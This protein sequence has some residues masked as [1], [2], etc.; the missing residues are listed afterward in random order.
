VA[1]LAE[2]YRAHGEDIPWSE[3]YSVPENA[4]VKWLM[5]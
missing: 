1:G 4:V 5:L 3:I 2:S